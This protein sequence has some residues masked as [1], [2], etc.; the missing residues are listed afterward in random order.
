[1]PFG[2]PAVSDENI[3]FIEQWID[4]GCPE[5]PLPPEPALM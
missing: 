5:D 3:K 1:M 4:D 2:F